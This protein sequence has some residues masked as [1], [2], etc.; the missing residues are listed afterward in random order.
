MKNSLLTLILLIS[1]A[2]LKAQYV[3]IPDPN[4]AA[5]LQTNVPSAMM[6]NQMDTTSLAVITTTNITVENLGIGDLTG[7][8]Y[9]D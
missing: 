8:Q 7:L 2:T 3:T 5:W 9:F 1:L 6:G 4:F